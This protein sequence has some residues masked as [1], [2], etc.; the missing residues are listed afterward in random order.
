MLYDSE[1][2]RGRFIR[3]H[4]QALIAHPRYE[5]AGAVDVDSGRRSRFEKLYRRPAFDEVDTALQ[6]TNPE[7]VVI[8]VPTPMH[9]DVA[10]RVLRASHPTAILCEK[11]LAPTST[12]AE[13]L[14]QACA[15]SDVR[16]FVNY[17]R[18]SDPGAVEVRSRI[19]AGSIIGPIKGVA[20]Y[21]KGFVHNG[22]HLFNLL[23]AWLGPVTNSRMIA[24]G[25]A[26]LS[27]P[28]PDVHVTF[29]RGSVVFLSAREEHFSHYTIE[30]LAANGRLRYDKAG[31]E[32]LWQPAKAHDTLPGYVVLSEDA[33]RIES[34]MGRYQWHVLNQISLALDGQT[35]NVCEGSE[36]LRTL[37]NLERI[38]ARED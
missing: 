17:I 16:L 38:L 4:A 11:P 28:E 8:S 23:E 7:F 29:G 36:A 18:R 9:V 30:L 10:L 27:D 1:T 32:I 31:E 14:V 24:P 22:S 6:A 26:P 5:L 13:M 25:E 3:S 34:G 20:W 19:L 12:E 33:E 15:G 21:S 35:A 2:E 37:R